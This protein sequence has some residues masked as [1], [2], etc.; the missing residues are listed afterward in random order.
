MIEFNK[1]TRYTKQ[2]IKHPHL[3]KDVIYKKHIG[4]I[5]SCNIQDY[6]NFNQTNKFKDNSYC[7]FEVS[8]D[9]QKIADYYQRMG[10]SS[11]T[12]EKTKKW[13]DEG[14]HCWLAIIDDKVVGGLWIFFGQVKINTLSARVLSKNKTIIFN[15][16][17]GYQGYVLIN[18]EYRGQGIYSSLNDYL[19]KYYYNLGEI[20][21]IMLITGA[22][23]GAVI[24]TIMNLQG[25]LIGIVEVKN[26]LGKTIRHEIFIDRKEKVWE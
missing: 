18:P 19:M 16:D 8:N 13:L 6:I 2:A 11:I 9:I 17:I 7:S 26:I 25:K 14:H 22:S 15:K 5:L 10:R 4:I 1:I 3:I 21:T 24:R 23:N 20:K 12:K